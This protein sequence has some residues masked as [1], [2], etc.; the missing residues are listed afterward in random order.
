MSTT[1]PSP[2]A[3]P[4][5][6]RRTQRSR[7]HRDTERGPSRVFR[8]VATGSGILLLA[9]LAAVAVFLLARGWAAIT[10]PSDVLAT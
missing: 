4:G 5:T 2:M 1:D 10:A 8:W 7:R 9:V 3:A 6:P